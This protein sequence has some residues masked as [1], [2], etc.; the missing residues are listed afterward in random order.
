MSEEH[1]PVQLI[2]CTDLDGAIGNKGKLLYDISADKRQ[3][4]RITHDTVLIMGRKTFESLPRVLPGRRHIVVT[5]QAMYHCDDPSVYLAY[6]LPSALE[7]AQAGAE[8]AISIIGGGQIYREALDSKKVDVIRATI[9]LDCHKEHDTKFSY[10]YLDTPEKLGFKLIDSDKIER[11]EKIG[12]KDVFYKFLT[13]HRE[14]YGLAI[15][16]EPLAK[17]CGRFIVI[18]HHN[19]NLRLAKDC[20][21]AYSPSGE[22]LINVVTYADNDIVIRSESRMERDRLISDLDS[23]F[24]A[25]VPQLF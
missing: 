12:G 18:K 8:K 6:S 16:E 21:M 19:G 17:D 5:N 14:G 11:S 25:A 9:V 22:L 15:K 10:A 3:F 23:I 4:A 1:K 24:L 7:M 2:V 20:V 13:Y